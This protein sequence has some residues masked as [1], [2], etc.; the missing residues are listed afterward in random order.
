M[1]VDANIIQKDH[2][3]SLDD[4]KRYYIK[5][6]DGGAHEAWL[7]AMKNDGKIK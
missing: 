1:Q 4:L 7:N 3:V 6:T 2:T 5:N